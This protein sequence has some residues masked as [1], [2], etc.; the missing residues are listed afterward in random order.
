M[1]TNGFWLHVCDIQVRLF[2]TQCLVTSSSGTV[3]FS[4][5]V[6]CAMNAN[7]LILYTDHTENNQK[8][9]VRQVR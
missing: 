2:I 4:G 6:E 8:K 1:W 7:I 9:K 5:F 3:Q